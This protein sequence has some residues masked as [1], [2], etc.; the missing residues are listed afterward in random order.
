MKSNK[1]ALKNYDFTIRFC[2]FTKLIVF[3]LPQK[4]IIPQVYN[5][6]TKFAFN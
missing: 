5:L 6:I 2:N 4:Y 1:L 3:F